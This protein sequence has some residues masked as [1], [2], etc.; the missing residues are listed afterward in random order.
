[1]GNVIL[2]S[3]EQLGSLVRAEKLPELLLRLL[4]LGAVWRGEVDSVVAQLPPQALG[5][6][7]KQRA[8]RLV[9]RSRAKQDVEVLG[10]VVEVGA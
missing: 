2:G 7:G 1:M 9:P 10:D 3:C 5:R 8:K 4:E 6:A